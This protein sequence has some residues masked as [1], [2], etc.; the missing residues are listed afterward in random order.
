[1]SAQIIQLVQGSAQWH[2]HR[3][4]MRNASET[5]A[6]LGLSPWV[7]PY[8][9]WLIKTG[10]ADQAVNAAMRHGTGLEPAAR[11][12]YEVETGH[13]MQP[14]VL[15]DG[16]YSASL[17][18]MTLDGELIVEIKCPMRGRSSTLWQAV[19]A[20]EVPPHY[21]AQIQHQ[22][23][24]SGAQ[25]AHLWVFDGERG[26]LHTI[27]PDAAAAAMIR[28]AWDAFMRF[29]DEDTPPPLTVPDTVH[30]EDSEWNSAAA[31][32]LAAKR[33][34][35]EAAASLDLA[36]QQL[37]ALA[38]HP[39][40]QGSGVTVTRYWKAGAVDYK[41]VPQLQGVALDPYR[42]RAREETRITTTA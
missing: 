39:R 28:D 4:A 10:R 12:A 1:M 35:D 3:R 38:Q 15:Q 8:R 24:V 34:A 32:Y 17:D 42:T 26:L 29:I 40:E 25:Q 30:R 22:L 20:G 9:L 5:P 31:A 18:G 14:L 11:H 33:C 23:M 41:R 19:A 16:P 27:T 36:R 7:T 13:V 2:A 37:V 21:A 6:V